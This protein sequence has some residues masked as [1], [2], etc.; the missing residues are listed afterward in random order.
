MLYVAEQLII[1]FLHLF[2]PS[3]VSKDDI[4]PDG[5]GRRTGNKTKPIHKFISI[6]IRG[7]KC[8]LDQLKTLST[9]HEYISSI[10]ILVNRCAIVGE[11]IVPSEVQIRFFLL[12]VNLTGLWSHTYIYRDL[13]NVTTFRCLIINCNNN[14]YIIVVSIK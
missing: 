3:V 9:M 5:Y 6:V 4:L 14:H 11:Y 1:K 7:K 10:M 13:K 2:Y 8:V 12:V